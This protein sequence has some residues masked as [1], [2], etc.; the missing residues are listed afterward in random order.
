MR[1]QSLLNYLHKFGMVDDTK[2]TKLQSVLLLHKMATQKDGR[3][4][5]TKKSPKTPE[6]NIG[7]PHI[8]KEVDTTKQKHEFLRDNGELPTSEQSFKNE[9]TEQPKSNT[10]ETTVA[11]QAETDTMHLVDTTEPDT[12]EK[13]AITEPSCSKQQTETTEK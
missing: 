13:L 11:K 1:T 9:H 3:S 7:P 5:E 4:E 6:K 2:L 8:N 10:T 12:T